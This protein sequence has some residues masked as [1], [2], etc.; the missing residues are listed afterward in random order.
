MAESIGPVPELLETFA[1]ANRK[2]RNVIEREIQAGIEAGD[3]RPGVDPA[4]QAVL[5][6]GSLRGVTLQRLVDPSGV[7]IDT[8][9]R[10]LLENLERALRHRQE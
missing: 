3:I 2:L 7:D 5:V 1:L 9:Q 6:V 10:Q 4:A 8:A